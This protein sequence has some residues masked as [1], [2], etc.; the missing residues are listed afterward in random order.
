[1]SGYLMEDRREAS[2][3]AAKVDAEQW[4]R[5]YVLSNVTRNA[6]ILSV[7]CGPATIEREVAKADSSFAVTGIDASLERC[8]WA[9]RTVGSLSNLRIVHANALRLPLPD[10]A[11]DFVYARFLLQHIGQAT[12]AISEMVRVCRPGGRVL[13]QDLDGQLVWHFPEIPELRETTPD[14]LRCLAQDGFDPHIGRK[15]YTYAHRA[16]LVR[17]ETQIAAYHAV[18]GSADEPTLARWRL[19]LDIA[20]PRLEVL[21]GANQTDRLLD[22]FLSHL[23]DP[24]TITYSIEFTVLGMKAPIQRT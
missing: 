7:G 16:G 1:M 19:K 23:E 4:A 15:L 21:V 11:F 24:E 13:L 18:L 9:K 6:S 2:R 20:R 22:A 12:E 14:L 8:G 5:T 17:L 10:N 3:L